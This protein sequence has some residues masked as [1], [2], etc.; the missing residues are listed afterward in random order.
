VLLPFQRT[1]L[2]FSVIVIRATGCA[3]QDD[4]GIRPVVVAQVS[5]AAASASATLSSCVVEGIRR[6][7]TQ[8]PGQ[9][10]PEHA[11]QLFGC[12]TNQIKVTALLLGREHNP[13]D[14]VFAEGCGQRAVYVER[15]WSSPREWYLVSRFSLRPAP[16]Q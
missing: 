9:L 11:A 16:G 8:C 2:L 13:T 6:E 3:G 15:P 1:L 5:A 4:A 10:I 7:V 12:P 14:A